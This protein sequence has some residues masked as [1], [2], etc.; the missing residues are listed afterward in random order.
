MQTRCL[1]FILIPLLIIALI[2]TASKEQSSNAGVIQGVK[3]KFAGWCQQF[4]KFPSFFINVSPNISSFYNTSTDAVKVPIRL[5][6]NLRKNRLEGG[7]FGKT[8]IIQSCTKCKMYDANLPWNFDK[9]NC[10]N[11]DLTLGPSS[12]HMDVCTQCSSIL[13]SGCKSNGIIVGARSIGRPRV[14]RRIL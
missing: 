8:P 6:S 5:N 7:T 4:S 12:I 14:C 11:S 13:G 1:T 10:G 9:K 2:V 3:I